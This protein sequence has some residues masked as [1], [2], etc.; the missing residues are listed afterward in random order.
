MKLNFK[1][2]FILIFSS[3]CG[4]GLYGSDAIDEPAHPW[5][6]H[7]NRDLCSYSFVSKEIYQ[8]TE[9]EDGMRALDKKNESTLEVRCASYPYADLNDEIFESA[10]S[11]TKDQHDD[12]TE[13]FEDGTYQ[14][15]DGSN[16]Q[17]GI[18]FYI[19]GR[20]KIERDMRERRK[21]PKIAPIELSK[22]AKSD[23]KV[24]ETLEKEIVHLELANQRIRKL[25]EEDV[26][27]AAEETNKAEHVR[28]QSHT[29]DET[30]TRLKG[31]QSKRLKAEEIV[32]SKDLDFKE[33]R[34]G[35]ID[36]SKD[37]AKFS[38]KQLR[39][40]QDFEASH[41][42]LTMAESLLD[43]ATT[44]VPGI[45][46]ARDIY[47]AVSGKHLI[48]AEELSV[49]ER[50]IAT[51]G[52]FSCGFFSKVKPV[53]R[54]IN[55]FKKGLNSE[56]A[57]KYAGKIIDSAKKYGFKN[58]EQVKNVAELSGKAKIDNLDSFL[59][60]AA[61]H[62]DGYALIFKADKAVEHFTKHGDRIRKFFG[63][64]SYNMKEYMQDA[65]HII[66]TGHYIPEA[67]AY[68]KILGGTG[69]EAKFAFVGMTRDSRNLTTFHIKKRTDLARVAPSLGL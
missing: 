36:L 15:S 7:N 54:V 61:K 23:R 50:G 24:T 12:S 34:Q 30:L 39:E 52:V 64:S 58:G 65:H 55:G 20:N 28:L 48:T 9:I 62:S 1:D 33:A 2:I 47:E 27:I 63:K 51:A 42:A 44:T 3:I 13:M 46:W 40:E 67:N 35:M 18:D 69:K 16:L 25:V 53:A 37:L 21:V 38:Y 66:K 4:F 10:Y 6:D 22:K 49:A 56:K 8:Y 11:R 29:Y 17:F 31:F 60:T 14:N 45:S 26:E 5:L 32:R 68:Y 41:V 59:S 19:D 57:L 43:L